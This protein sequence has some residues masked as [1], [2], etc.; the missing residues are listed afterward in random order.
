MEEL[1]F[2]IIFIVLSIAR[3]FTERRQPARPVRPP[4]PRGQA[5]PGAPQRTEVVLRVPAGGGY[6]QGMPLGKQRTTPSIRENTEETA[7]EQVSIS[8]VPP[9]SPL[10]EM[11]DD[12]LFQL[13]RETV[14]LGLVFSEL[15]REPRARHRWLRRTDFHL[16]S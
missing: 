6:G 14:L 16:H 5:D 2:F 9:A 11:E 15:L 7:Q 13:D 12:A 3:S 1:I 10:E 8:A 4:T